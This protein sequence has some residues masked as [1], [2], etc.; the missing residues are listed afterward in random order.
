M[1]VTSYSVQLTVLM[2]VTTVQVKEMGLVGMDCECLAQDAQRLFEIYWYLS[3]PGAVVPDNWPSSYTAIF[4]MENPANININGSATE[5]YWAVRKH[6]VY[7][8]P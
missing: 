1:H 5:A 7:G 3:G 6:V 4:N 8:Y 2:H